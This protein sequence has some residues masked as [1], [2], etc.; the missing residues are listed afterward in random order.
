MPARRSNKKIPMPGDCR[1]IIMAATKQQL[2]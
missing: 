2:S 1:D